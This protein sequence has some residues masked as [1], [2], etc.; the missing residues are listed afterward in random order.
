[1][2]PVYPGLEWY[3]AIS[4]RKR[5]TGRCSFAALTRC[6][7]YY[8]SV[9]LLSDAGITTKL[10][11]EREAA[12]QAMW[13]EHDA[14]P[15]MAE[16]SA[17]TSGGKGQ[18][19]CFSNFCP[20]VSFDIFKLFATTLIRH[21]D[22]IDREAAERAIAADGPS[23][24]KDWRWNWQHVEPM[25]YSECPVYAKLYPEK[26]MAEINFHGPVSGQVNVAGDTI[27]SPVMTLTFQDIVACID[28]SDAPPAEKEAAKSKL[29]AFL[30]HPLVTSL[31]GGIAGG[32]VG[33]V[34]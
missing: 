20:E 5:L 28:A 11:P 32:A 10:P 21:H 22:E 9:A 19:N 23:N 31:V 3:A 26:K 29:A 18:P 14:W 7:R 8:E 15:I 25:H 2:R 34:K 1:M 6:P 4:E 30:T 16:N 13:E 27:N 12:L 24:G 17:S 33:L